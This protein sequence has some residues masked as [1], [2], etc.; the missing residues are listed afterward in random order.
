M[1]HESC[2]AA[3]GVVVSHGAESGNVAS[4]SDTCSC[5]HQPTPCNWVGNGTYYACLQGAQVAQQNV[6]NGMSYSRHSRITAQR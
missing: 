4:S 1:Q 5:E 3:I 6:Y 2:A